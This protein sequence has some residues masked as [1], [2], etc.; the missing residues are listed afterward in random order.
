MKFNF[1]NY[2]K[3]KIKNFLI[4][5]N[6][7]LFSYNA[8]QNSLNWLFKEQ[9]LHE[10]NFNYYKIYNNLAIKLIKK[11]SFKN[12]LHIINSSFFLLKTKQINN[13]LL[14]N[15]NLLLKSFQNLQFNIYSL[16]LN[17]KLYYISQLKKINSLK[18]NNSIK[19]LYQFLTTHLK[20][21]YTLTYK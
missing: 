6:F 20:I 10:L 5:N 18:Y 13:K 12:S 8:N 2:Q 14:I 9:G 19:I 15:K 11:T 17:N 3:S 16:K 1:K 4:Q 7:I 21:C